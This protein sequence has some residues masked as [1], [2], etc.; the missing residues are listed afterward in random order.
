[1]KT[2]TKLILIAIGIIAPVLLFSPLE[3]LLSW[4]IGII[5]PTEQIYAEPLLYVWITMWYM[6]LAGCA[7]SVA[8]NALE[9]RLIKK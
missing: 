9:K 2:K 7:V 8:G 5:S 4:G 1:M 3:A 6:F